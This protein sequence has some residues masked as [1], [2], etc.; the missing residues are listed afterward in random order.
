MIELFILLFLFIIGIIVGSFLN[1]LIDRIPVGKDIVFERSHCDS[2]SKKLQIP[3]LIPI[4]SYLFLKGQCRY[5]RAKISI[6]NPAI[7]II[8]GLF[9]I[10]IYFYY[11]QYL[12]QAYF[13]PQFVYQII[14][15]SILT[16]IFFIDLKESIIPD[17]LVFI[18]VFVTVVFRLI[19]LPSG[20]S[21]DIVCGIIF[22]FFFLFL[23][24]I[25]RGRGMGLGDVKFAL[26]MG[27][28]L[29]FPRILVAFYIA[30]LTGAAISLILV[31]RK[32]K[33]FKSSIPFGPFLVFAS[34]ISQFYG[35]TILNYILKFL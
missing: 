3:D 14:I 33:T 24:I 7:E 9:F 13:L 32:Q 23:V 4:F 6:R 17:S 1:V 30:F 28:Y 21:A 15:L 35:L 10:L 16:V 11:A 34:I 26:F 20:L 31:L 27:L 25:T 18:M 19:Y 8:S 2:C 5:C 29:G 22:S 12:M